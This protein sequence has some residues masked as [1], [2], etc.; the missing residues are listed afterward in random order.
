MK[1]ILLA[2]AA[3]S[4]LHGQ[5]GSIVRADPAL[6][7]LI[8]PGAKI[9]K[10]AGD[11]R[12]TEGPVWEKKGGL[13]YFSDLMQNAILKW[14]P[15]GKVTDFRKPVFTGVFP[16]GALTGTNGL[17]LDRQGRLVAAEHG[18]RRIS[19]TEKSGFITTLAE[20][21]EGKRLNSPNDLV[22]KR[23]GQIYFTDPPGLF[24]TFP[25]TPDA[26]KREMDFAG[27]YRITKRGELELLAKDVPYPNGI[28]FSPDEKKLYVS[29]SRPEKF[30]MVY[31]V[32]GDGVIA[33]GRKFFDATAIAGD[34]VPDGMK[35][36][37]AGN[38]YATGPAGLM[39][40]SPEAKLLGTL[41]LPELP[42][43]C[44]WGDADAKSLYITARTSI[45][46]I[47]VNVAG[48]RN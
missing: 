16:D 29:N 23:D 18:N 41:V 34:N 1:Q 17:A 11:L 42:S 7:R 37:T 25:P 8:A 36:D 22:I 32:V 31:E 45:Y 21:Y 24:R 28:A 3:A 26:P 20:R 35:V 15:G 13:L 4:A 5:T 48:A 33:N 19:R 12:F 40:F 10:V 14:T 44:A 27:V 2:L 38:V 30:W 47:R 9:E 39:I 46:K 43:N 6:D